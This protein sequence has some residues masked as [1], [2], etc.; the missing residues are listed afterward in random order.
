MNAIV[1]ISIIIV[2]II[3]VVVIYNNHNKTTIVT[4]CPSGY[5]LQNGTCYSCPS[6]TATGNS[7]GTSFVEGCNCPANNIWDFGNNICISCPTGSVVSSVG[8]S[9]NVIGCKCPI[10]YVWLSNQNSCVQCMGG[11]DPNYLG[12]STNITGC[13]CPQGQSWVNNV[14]TQNSL[15]VTT[16]IKLYNP[17]K[18]GPYYTPTLITL[19]DYEEYT[20]YG[21]YGD[22]INHSIFSSPNVVATN[23]NV[24]ENCVNASLSNYAIGFGIEAGNECR[25]FNDIS[26][27]TALGQIQ[28]CN[29]IDQ[30]TKLPI[31]GSYSANIYQVGNWL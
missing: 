26:Q 2:L 27:V 9:T 1:L 10:G 3:I 21:C 6:G 30:T 18:Y 7:G 31:G 23:P 8:N 15:S 5:S 14:C 4:S 13:F 16:N 25:L 22:D 17:P 28:N 11:S 24:F 29:N 12:A 19:P 20:S